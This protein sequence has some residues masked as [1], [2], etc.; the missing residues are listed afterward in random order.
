MCNLLAEI[1]SRNKWL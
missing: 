1:L